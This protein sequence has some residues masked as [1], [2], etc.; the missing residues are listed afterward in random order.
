MK[1]LVLKKIFF[2]TDKIVAYFK[3]SNYC[4][5]VVLPLS[6]RYISVSFSLPFREMNTETVELTLTVM[7]RKRYINCDLISY[8]SDFLEIFDQNASGLQHFFGS[9][10]SS[11]LLI[12]ILLT[13]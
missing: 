2:T 4:V 1:Y 3:K 8:I 5:Y 13:I 6:L 10:V 12:Y 7:A 9:R 11:F